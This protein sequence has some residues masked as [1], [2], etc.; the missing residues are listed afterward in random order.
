MS[1]DTTVCTPEEVSLA[2]IDGFYCLSH[3]ESVGLTVRPLRNRD[4][5]I[6]MGLQV[7]TI[8]GFLSLAAVSIM[9]AL[10]IVSRFP[11]FHAQN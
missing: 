5:I 6:L 11:P 10:I 9:F 3:T 1:S 8:T 4:E 2:G 7:V